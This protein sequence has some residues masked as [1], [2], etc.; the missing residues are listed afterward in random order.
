M[1]IG[2]D[3]YFELLGFPKLKSGF[4][5]IETKLGTTIAGK[6]QITSKHNILSIFG[7]KREEMKADR[8]NQ[9]KSAVPYFECNELRENFWK[10]FN[11]LKNDFTNIQK[12]EN[13]ELRKK[14]KLTKK[15]IHK[16]LI[17]SQTM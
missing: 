7:D 12:I 10:L 15:I 6:G 17:I 16:K 9:K 14:M 2:A 11:Q 8:K 5:L 3:H 4:N 1:L 13:S